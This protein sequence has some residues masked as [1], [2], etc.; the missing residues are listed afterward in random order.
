MGTN[1]TMFSKSTKKTDTS[2]K[3]SRHHHKHHHHKHKHGV[4]RHHT[5]IKDAG[6]HQHR[7][8]VDK[9]VHVHPVTEK[10]YHEHPIVEKHIHE[11]PVKEEHLHQHP[12]TE[13]H[14]D[15]APSVTKKDIGTAAA[16]MVDGKTH[17]HASPQ[18]EVIQTHIHDTAVDKHLHEH[19]VLE[20]HLEVH[21]VLEEH[22]HEHPVTEKHIHQHPIT[23]THQDAG[24]TEV[25]K[26]HLDAD[27]VPKLDGKTHQHNE[28]KL[29]TTVAHKHKPVVDEHIH[30][31]PKLEKHIHE[32]PVKEEHVHTHPVLEEHIHA[33]PVQVKD[34]DRPAI[35]N[36]EVIDEK[37]VK[38]RVEGKAPSSPGLNRASGGKVL[39]K[40]KRKERYRDGSDTAVAV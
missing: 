19:P 35:V 21:P 7:T 14:V 23:E 4:E 6:V 32:H 2:K 22:I 26:T 40:S 28:A 39:S 9:H 30:I 8:E 12:I 27:A 10:H 13:T 20:K 31:H 29:K 36:K 11:H 34:V 3:S 16:P 1:T 18:Q 25:K 15:T 38:V 5:E 17:L 37:P 33:H 24:V